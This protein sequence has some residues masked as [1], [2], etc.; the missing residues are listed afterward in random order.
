[1]CTPEIEE[2]A[3]FAGNTVS[4]VE[5]LDARI[6]ELAEKTAQG[7]AHLAVAIVELRRPTRWERFVAW[8]R[9]NIYDGTPVPLFT[10]TEFDRQRWAYGAGPNTLSGSEDL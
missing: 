7:L 1:M 3:E 9:E 5:R 8:F 4:E 6:T 2:L 10:Q